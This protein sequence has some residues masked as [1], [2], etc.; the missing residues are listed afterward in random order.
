M[1][2]QCDL[3]SQP[4][5]KP[6]VDPTLEPRVDSEKPYSQG[7]VDPP[8]VSACWQGSVLG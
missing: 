6:S 4:S 7:L 3:W 2:A 8:R 5:P 1:D